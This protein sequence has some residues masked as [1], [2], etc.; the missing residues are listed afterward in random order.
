MLKSFS[1]LEAA[2]NGMR[3][4]FG[5]SWVWVAVH[6][7]VWA[8]TLSKQTTAVWLQDEAGQLGIIELLFLCPELT[9]NFLA[10]TRLACEMSNKELTVFYL[11]ET[12]LFRHA[13]SSWTEPH[14]ILSM[15]LISPWKDVLG[16]LSE[17]VYPRMQ[18][19]L[20]RRKHMQTWIPAMIIS[21]LGLTKNWMILNKLITL[22]LDPNRI[23]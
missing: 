14:M 13:L 1:I 3:E 19:K 12:R 17:A 10:S 5:Y 20:G 8:H 7:C 18:Q 2:A 15:L 4:L 16:M 22:R 6:V 11:I 9:Q 21:S 23:F